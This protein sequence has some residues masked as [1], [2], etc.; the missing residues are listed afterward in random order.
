MKRGAREMTEKIEG[1][2][3]KSRAAEGGREE[4]VEENDP[5]RG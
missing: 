1:M 4:G 5:G 3:G 2:E